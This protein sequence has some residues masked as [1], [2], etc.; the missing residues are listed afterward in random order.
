MPDGLATWSATR[1]NVVVHSSRK[2]APP[3]STPRAAADRI[4]AT[5]SHRSC[6][7]SAVTSAKSTEAITLRAD[8]SPPTRAST[9]RLSSW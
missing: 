4:S 8:D 2:S 6:S 1:W 3:A 5:S 9:P 7:C